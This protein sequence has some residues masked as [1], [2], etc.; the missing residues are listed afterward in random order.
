MAGDR[1][2]PLSANHDRKKNYAIFLEHYTVYRDR[3]FQKLTGRT[4]SDS[5]QY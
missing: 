3:S 1:N 5:L 4:A 2:G